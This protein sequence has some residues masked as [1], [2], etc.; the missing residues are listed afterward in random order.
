MIEPGKL[1]SAIHHHL[2]LGL[3]DDSFA[4]DIRTLNAN[5]TGAVRGPDVFGGRYRNERGLN[6]RVS[7][8]RKN[9]ARHEK[10]MRRG[11]F[12][13]SRRNHLSCPCRAAIDPHGFAALA[14]TMVGHTGGAP[15]RSR[16]LATGCA[17]G[18]IGVSRRAGISFSCH[19][20]NGEG[21]C[22]HKRQQGRGRKNAL[23]HHR[24][25]F[26]YIRLCEMVARTIRGR[27]ADGGWILHANG[28]ANRRLKR[29]CAHVVSTSRDVVVR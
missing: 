7:L 4:P 5:P 9:H 6:C 20:G 23:H 17:G 25:Q 10:P 12:P 18:G 15:R 16:D 1:E 2:A 14:R 13:C 28:E 26:Y 3:I 27:E 21:C 22:H 8:G 29:S 19:G 11:Y 24:L